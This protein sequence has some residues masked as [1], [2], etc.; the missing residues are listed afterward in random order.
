MYYRISLGAFVSSQLETIRNQQ[1][2]KPG[3]LTLGNVMKKQLV[4]YPDYRIVRP[5]VTQGDNALESM[6]YSQDLWLFTSVV[7]SDYSVTY[8]LA[9]TSSFDHTVKIWRYQDGT[10]ESVGT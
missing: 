5:V 9:F 4:A 10:I 1:Y 2:N 6:R 7:S 8:D 3:N